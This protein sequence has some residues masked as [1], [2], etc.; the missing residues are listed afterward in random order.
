[1]NAR[2]PPTS[3]ERLAARQASSASITKQLSVL[4]M[5]MICAAAIAGILRWA[6][7]QTNPIWVLPVMASGF[8]CFIGF[9]ATL[10]WTMRS[11]IG[12]TPRPVVTGGLY[13]TALLFVGG[14]VAYGS[15]VPRAA[16]LTPLTIAVVLAALTTIAALRRRARITKIATL[17]RGTHAK[18]TVTDD[19]LAEFAATPNLKITTITVS[20]R[21][22]SNVER[23]ITPRATQAPSR[24]IAVGDSVDV[25]FD[26]AAPG[27]INRIVVEHDNG[28]SRIALSRPLK[29]R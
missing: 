13:L 19:G 27:D 16:Y 11:A 21:D 14:V 25:W 24:P 10:S 28:A 2:P 8:V 15:G 9:L 20:F 22:A 17:R 5:G 23:W 1:M 6:T 26:A 12:S 3:A 29:P 4:I 18:G 7:E